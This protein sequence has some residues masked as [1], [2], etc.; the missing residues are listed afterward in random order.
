M[1]TRFGRQARREQDMRSLGTL[2]AG[3]AFVLFAVPSVVL[4]DGRVALVVGNSCST[5]RDTARRWTTRTS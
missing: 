2:V 1:E 4:A 3:L 5:S